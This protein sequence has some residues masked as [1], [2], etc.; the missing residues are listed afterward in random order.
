MLRFDKSRPYGEVCPPFRPD[1]CD[2]VA[3][4]DQGGN[5]FC[6]AGY[7]II[8]G[9]PLKIEAPEAASAPETAAQMS[10]EQ[11]LRDASSMAHAEFKKHA[12]AILGDT[13][14]GGK[15]AIL[16]SLKKHLAVYQ[17]K[18]AERQS[19]HK[20]L[21]WDAMTGGAESQDGE[22]PVAAPPVPP[23]APGTIDLAAWGRGQREYLWA[24]VR[25]AIRAKYHTGVTQRRDAVNL[26]IDQGLIRAAEARADAA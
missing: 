19:R 11:L 9:K 5:L 25:K 12:K 18:Q 26:L 1:G 22:P 16:E 6:A 20:G 8:P 24:E 2:R 7:Q 17:A 23:A 21:S 14:P 3:M 15:A 13:C 10:V 4:Y